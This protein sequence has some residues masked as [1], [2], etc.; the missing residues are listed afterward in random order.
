MHSGA[1]A[2]R[3]QPLRGPT[4]VLNGDSLTA[5]A[6]SSTTL[7]TWP[8]RLLRI[9]PAPLY[10]RNYAAGGTT[11]TQIRA[12]ILAMS[13]ADKAHTQFIC[14]GKPEQND[15]ATL[16]GFA[17]DVMAE[18]PH[19]RVVLCTPTSGDYAELYPAGAAYQ[20]RIDAAAYFLSEYP[21]NTL[22]L[23]QILLD[24]NDGSANDLTDVANGIVPRSLR[25]DN[26]HW[27]DTCQA[28]VAQAVAD[29]LFTKEWL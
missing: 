7:G 10:I 4:L 19:G 3:S 18:F 14:F 23:H 15:A 5:G 20:G 21:D 24:A 12:A 26:I 9:L 16:I 1:N 25:T 27:N 6:G 8:Y 17:D 13:A 29:F 28:V 11:D 22:D 2:A